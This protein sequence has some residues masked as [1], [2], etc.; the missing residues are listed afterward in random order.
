MTRSMCCYPKGSATLYPFLHVLYSDIAGCKWVF[1]VKYKIHGT[2]DAYKVELVVKVFVQMDIVNYLELFS[3]VAH[4][5]S[6]RFK[7]FS[8][9]CE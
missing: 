9:H 8:Y 2:I 7:S 1:F 4:M 5:S 3:L 6:T